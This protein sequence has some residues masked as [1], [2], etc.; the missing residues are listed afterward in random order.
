MSLGGDGYSQS[1]QSAI[2]DAWEHNVLIVAAAGNTGDTSLEYPGAA[3]HVLGVAATD[4]DNAPAGFSTYGN[5]VR[6][7]APGVNILSTLPT[8]GSGYGSNYGALAGTSTA[9]PQVAAL[10]GLLFMANPGLTAQAAI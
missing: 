9:T 7:A 2:D 5:W 8:Y 10:A 6:I 1:L 4:T 3:N